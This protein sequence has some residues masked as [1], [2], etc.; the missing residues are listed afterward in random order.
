MLTTIHVA[1]VV[2]GTSVKRP[3]RVY[4]A[5][6]FG[7]VLKGQVHRVTPTSHNTVALTKGAMPKAKDGCRAA[8]L[9]DLGIASKPLPAFIE[10]RKAAKANTQE[11]PAPQALKLTPELVAQMIAMLKGHA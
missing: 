2:N 10:A 6:T 1:L 11:T 8:K 9:A 3:L 4:S 5:D 7:V